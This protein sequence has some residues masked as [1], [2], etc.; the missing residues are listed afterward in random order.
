MPPLALARLLD[1]YYIP[2]DEV[3]GKKNPLSLMSFIIE[4]FIPQKTIHLN[5]GYTSTNKPTT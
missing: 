5:F 1:Y 4:E 3:P 2:D